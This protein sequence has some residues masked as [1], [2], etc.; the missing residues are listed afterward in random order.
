MWPHFIHL[1]DETPSAHR[2]TSSLSLN[3]MKLEAIRQMQAEEEEEEEDLEGP[4]AQDDN[5]SQEAGQ[6]A[7]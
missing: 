3:E 2:T 4:R 7:V 1:A 5:A 6:K